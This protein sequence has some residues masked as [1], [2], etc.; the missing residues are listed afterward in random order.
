MKNKLMMMTL[1]GLLAGRTVL[2]ADVAQPTPAPAAPAAA[3]SGTPK[4]KFEKVVYDFG[5]TS[6]VQMVVGTFAFQ[7]DGDGELVLQKPTTSCGCTVASVKPESLKLKPGE[8]GEI[9]FTLS[10]GAARGSVEK[11]ITV[12]SNDPLA[13]T[14]GLSIKA[15]M[16]VLIDA[17]PLQVMLGEMPVGFSTNVTLQI[18]RTDGKPLNLAKV[19]ASNPFITSKVEPVAGSTGTA[20][21]VT[22]QIKPDGQPRNFYERLSVYIDNVNYPVLT[23]PVFG[24]L[25]GDLRI[26]PE[27]VF[28]GIPDPENWPG[29]RPDL[30]QI[31]SI[32]ISPSKADQVFE[33][34]KATSNM[35]ELELTISPVETGKVYQVVAKLTVAP[36][37]TKVGTITLETNLA[38]HPTVEIPVNINVM[39]H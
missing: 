37:E 10:V 11:H 34:R 21:T 9:G 12:N 22:L 18:R 38:G 20:A 33:V 2:A 7:N 25:M 8:K 29:P 36:K 27:R 6:M 26:Q 31:R 14:T 13:P 17:V 30:M 16:M 5:T 32:R 24:Q 15:N 19:E 1:A 35:P 39:R 28:W 3:P 23:I 4:I